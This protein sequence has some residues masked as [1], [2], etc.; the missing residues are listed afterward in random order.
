MLHAWLQSGAF[1]L[2][3][4]KYLLSK[5]H[6]ANDCA[7]H[8][9]TLSVQMEKQNEISSS[10]TVAV[11]ALREMVKTHQARFE[12]EDRYARSLMRQKPAA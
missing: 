3:A 4:I 9:K 7:A 5:A 11:D 2:A 8:L 10:L 1:V 6:Q 12:D